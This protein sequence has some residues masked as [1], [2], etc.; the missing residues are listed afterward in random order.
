MLTHDKIIERQCESL[1]ENANMLIVI[2]CFGYLEAD[3]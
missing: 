3:S 1:V 2:H